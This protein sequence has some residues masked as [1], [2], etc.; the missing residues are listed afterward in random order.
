MILQLEATAEGSPGQVGIAECD[1]RTA[2]RRQQGARKG[3]E[4]AASH[5]KKYFTK[6]C[7]RSIFTIKLRRRKGEGT[8]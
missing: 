3:D 2:A 7:D 1:R 8:R 5:T 6:N 4:K